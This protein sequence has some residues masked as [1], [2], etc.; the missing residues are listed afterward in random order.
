[1]DLSEKFLFCDT[2]Q[3]INI[4][5]FNVTNKSNDIAQAWTKLKCRR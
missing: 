4:G 1:M 5:W 3:C 2:F